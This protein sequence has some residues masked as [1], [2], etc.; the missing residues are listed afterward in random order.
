[1]NTFGSIEL[2]VRWIIRIV[3]V[4]VLLSSVI[5]LIVGFSG[6]VPFF[7]IGVLVLG[8]IIEVLWHIMVGD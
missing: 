6:I 5:G 3:L 1:M 2:S 7:I 4:F 8:L